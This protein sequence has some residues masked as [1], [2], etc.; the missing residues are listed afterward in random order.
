MWYPWYLSTRDYYMENSVEGLKN[1]EGLDQRTT[2]LMFDWEN[3]RPQTTPLYSTFSRRS[4][5][6]GGGEKAAKQFILLSVKEEVNFLQV[7]KG[8]QQI[9]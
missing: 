5:T 2:R 7:N 9:N 4:G 3:E 1:V 6:G 8:K